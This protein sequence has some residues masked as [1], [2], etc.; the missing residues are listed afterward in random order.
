VSHLE[1]LFAGRSSVP[2]VSAIDGASHSLA[3]L[4]SALGVQQVA[5]GVDEFGQS[6]SLA[7]VYDAHD[8]SADAIAGAAIAAMV[9]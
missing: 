6:G 9:G 4:G 1:R 8:V 5:L 7:D 3:F 2:L